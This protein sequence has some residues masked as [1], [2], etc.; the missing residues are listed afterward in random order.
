MLQTNHHVKIPNGH[1]LNQ[2][3]NYGMILSPTVKTLTSPY[4]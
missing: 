2:R 4:M 1:I 3:V